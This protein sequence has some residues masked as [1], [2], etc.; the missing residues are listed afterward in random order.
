MF[1]RSYSST[2]INQVLHLNIVSYL[3]PQKGDGRM[4]CH[5]PQN[6]R[7]H[8]EHSVWSTRERPFCL[9]LPVALDPWSPSSK[10]SP[11]SNLSKTIGCLS[12]RGFPCKEWRL[13]SQW[14]RWDVRPQ[15]NDVWI[16]ITKHTGKQTGCCVRRV[17]IKRYTDLLLSPCNGLLS[18]PD[19]DWGLNVAPGHADVGT[20]GHPCAQ[21]IYLSIIQ[22]PT[23][24]YHFRLAKCF[25]RLA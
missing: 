21:V 18:W 5:R 8:P 15:R 22:G 4:Y 23:T 7:R 10:T 24:C 1:L 6:R 20:K 11:A 9:I 12:G 25:E 3:P 14:T 2:F 16:C 19:T 13:L 17:Q